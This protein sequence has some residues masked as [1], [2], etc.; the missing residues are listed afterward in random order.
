MVVTIIVVASAFLAAALGAY[1]QRF[2]TPDPRPEITAVGKD[3]GEQ[4]RSMD[5]R[6]QITALAEQIGAMDPRPAIGALQQRI[7]A[8][9]QER[10]EIENFT[11]ELRLQQATQ[12]NYIVSATNNSDLDAKAEAVFIE[13]QGIPLCRP[14]KPRQ[15]QDWTIKKNSS[16]QMDFAPQPDPVNQLLYGSIA[17]PT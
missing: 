11:L 9:E 1:L 10:T 15:G 13:Y 6:P 3:L 14:T 5:A 12:G 16:I 4:M 17:P 8:I 2:W 7:E